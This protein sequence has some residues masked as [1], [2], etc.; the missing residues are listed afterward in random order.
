[1]FRRSILLLAMSGGLPGAVCA[2]PDP[3]GVPAM[4]V[5]SALPDVEPLTLDSLLG[6]WGVYDRG[7]KRWV[8]THRSCAEWDHEV[9]WLD[10]DGGR[11]PLHGDFKFIWS[12]D[13]ALWY[14]T[15]RSQQKVGD[16]ANPDGDMII[17]GAGD[18]TMVLLRS[19]L[20]NF[21]DGMAKRRHV[22][23]TAAKEARG[24]YPIEFFEFRMWDSALSPGGNMPESA[25]RVLKCIP[26]PAL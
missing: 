9:R 16:I 1:M 5:E 22:A 10:F 13:G 26:G 21:R 25:H 4:K 11:V 6:D 18:Q 17:F 3:A 7:Q 19:D 8:G 2:E 15:Q 20:H 23:D 14:L 12:H 24:G